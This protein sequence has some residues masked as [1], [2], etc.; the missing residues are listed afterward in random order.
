VRSLFF[1]FFLLHVY[2]EARE[3]GDSRVV[4]KQRSLYPIPGRDSDPAHSL[5]INI[6]EDPSRFNS[7]LVGP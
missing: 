4:L 7:A 1:F 6:R 2:I 3:G 5:L